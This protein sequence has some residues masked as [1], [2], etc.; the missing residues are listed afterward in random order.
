M[1]VRN[2]IIRKVVIILKKNGIIKKGILKL[3][4]GEIIKIQGMNR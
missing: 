4:L 1:Q 2:F 3:I